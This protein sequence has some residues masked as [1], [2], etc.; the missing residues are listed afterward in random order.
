M[1][2]AKWLDIFQL[3]PDS[4]MSEVM[5]HCFEL[6]EE[7][8]SWLF[9]VMTEIQDDYCWN[10]SASLMIISMLFFQFAKNFSCLHPRVASSGGIEKVVVKYRWLAQCLMPLI[11]KRQKSAC[12]YVSRWQRPVRSTHFEVTFSAWNFSSNQYLNDS[13]TIIL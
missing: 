7:L 12:D 3:L 2:T 10:S 6:H 11:I 5:V 8:S 9:Y 1:R 4:W 13:T